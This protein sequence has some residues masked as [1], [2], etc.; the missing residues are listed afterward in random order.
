MLYFLKAG[1]LNAFLALLIGCDSEIQKEVLWGLSNLAADCDKVI[2][3]IIHH[4]ILPKVVEL[5]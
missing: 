1:V 3:Q 2:K 4:D 5:T